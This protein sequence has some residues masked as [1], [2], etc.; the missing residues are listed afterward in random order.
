MIILLGIIRISL[1]CLMSDDVVY[2]VC[3]YI[4][5]EYCGFGGY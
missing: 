4:D 3:C 5:I 1:L 2:I